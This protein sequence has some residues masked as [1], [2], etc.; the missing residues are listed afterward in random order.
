MLTAVSA[1]A[2]LLDDDWESEDDR[3]IDDR[4]SL[5][6]RLKIPVRMVERPLT[7]TRKM[8]GLIFDLGVTQVGRGTPL[9]SFVAG[10]GYGLTDETEIGLILLPLTLSRLKGSGL[11]TP[12]VFGRHRFLSSDLFEM[13]VGFNSELPFSSG[14]T[15]D[16]NLPMR[17]HIGPY[18]NVDFTLVAG[19]VAGPGFEPAFSTPLEVGVQLAERLALKV[20]ARARLADFERRRVLANAWLHLG[21]TITGKRGAWADIGLIVNSPNVVLHGDLPPD[22]EIGNYFFAGA[23]TRFFIFQQSDY[24]RVD[25]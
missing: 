16:L 1:H 20:G 7:L 19:A 23:V 14:L 15:F 22:P 6:P 9:V 12:S 25:F 8:F 2:G 11:S 4:F 10:T 21:Y 13:A 17:V 3:D 18:A 24:R 5:A